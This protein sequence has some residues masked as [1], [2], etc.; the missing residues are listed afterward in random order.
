MSYLRCFICNEDVRIKLKPKLM[1]F[2][3]GKFFIKYDM[4]G[5]CGCGERKIRDTNELLLYY[6]GK[7][8]KYKTLKRDGI[9]KLIF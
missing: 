2:L 7:N 3:S 9:R 6:L 1:I 5:R 8:I 4:Y